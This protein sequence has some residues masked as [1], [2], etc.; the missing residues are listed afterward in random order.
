MPDEPEPKPKFTQ[1]MTMHLNGGKSYSELHFRVYVDGCE[2]PITRHKRTNGSPRYLIT[3]DNFVCGEDRFDNFVARG[4]G[5]R[6]WLIAHCNPGPAEPDPEP[7][8]A[9]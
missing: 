3:D 8:P 5:L 7:E 2:T 1:S 9:S 4:V 6:E